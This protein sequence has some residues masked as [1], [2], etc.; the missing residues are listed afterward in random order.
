MT[1]LLPGRFS[2]AAEPGTVSRKQVGR[3]R[4]KAG[5][6][7]KCVAVL[8]PWGE[9]CVPWLCLPSLCQ[10]DCGVRYPLSF[11]QRCL[12]LHHSM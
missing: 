8:V 3:R 10:Q 2:F 1:V 4:R 5:E 11:T 6:T 9:C 12:G 7:W